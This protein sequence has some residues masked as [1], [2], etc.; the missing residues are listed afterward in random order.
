MSGYLYIRSHPERV[1]DACHTRSL[2]TYDF[3]LS[4]V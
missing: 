1:R 3:N 2:G 4:N